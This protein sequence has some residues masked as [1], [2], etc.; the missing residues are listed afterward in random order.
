[1]NKILIDWDRIVGKIKPMHCV[2][3]APLCGTSNVLWDTLKEAG[4]PYSRLHDTGG[5]YGQNRY[6][7]IPNI[8]RDFDADVND[9]AS[10]DFAF[11]DWLLERLIEQGVKPFFR[12]G[13]SIENACK[14]KAYHIFPPKDCLKWAKI[15]EHIIMHYNEGWANG[16]H[17]GIEYWEI[18][19]EPDNEID[20]LSNPMWRGTMNQYFE[21]YE[22]TATY[23]KNRFPHLKIG[24]YGSCGFYAV[25]NEKVNPNANISDRF[26]YF[27]Y[28]FEE[29]L[30]YISSKKHKSPLDFFSWHS[31]S[32]VSSNVKY[33]Q[34][35]RE[36]LD[37][38]GFAETESILNE[39]NPGIEKRGLLEDAANIASMMCALQKAPVDMLMYY[40]AQVN[41]SYCG[42]YDPLKKKTFK[43]YHVFCMFDKLYR[44]QN[45]VYCKDILPL[46]IVAA[47]NGG[48]GGILIVNES[49]KHADFY[50]D[51]GSFSEIEIFRIGS[52]GDSCSSEYSKI[53]E[54]IKFKLEAYEIVY[55]GLR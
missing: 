54:D 25:L 15:C 55:F 26:E 53:S 40:D 38:Y 33:A 21:L 3:N 31:Y 14:I 19:N 28:F 6:V 22:T 39:W 13:V 34:Y 52:V 12:L 37:K 23:L 46:R 4:I 16:F 48:E 9:E 1:M 10:Y 50:L 7:D 8:F 30:K 47:K 29:F 5:S 43:A 24:G 35:A 42:L 36:M 11:T 2:N 32:G 20:P 27:I 41:S 18:W 44:L 51:C 45:E 17:Y 49:G